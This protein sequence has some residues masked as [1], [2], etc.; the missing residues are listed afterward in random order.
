MNIDQLATM[1]IAVIVTMFVCYVLSLFAVAGNKLHILYVCLYFGAGAAL[2][3]FFTRHNVRLDDYM[4]DFSQTLLL[5][6]F[7]IAA[8]AV[9]RFYEMHKEVLILAMG[10]EERIVSTIVGYDQITNKPMLKTFLVWRKV[11]EDSQDE[12]AKPDVE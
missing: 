4:S 9:L 1:Q 8:V 5:A 10:Y 3:A 12:K 2:L 6:F 11:T 7:C